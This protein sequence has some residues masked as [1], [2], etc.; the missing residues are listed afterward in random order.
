MAHKKAGSNTGVAAEALERIANLRLMYGV[1]EGGKDVTVVRWA[2]KQN[3]L[4]FNIVPGGIT[5]VSASTFVP[6]PINPGI[7]RQSGMGRLRHETVYG[8]MVGVRG[9]ELRVL[10]DGSPRLGCLGVYGYWPGGRVDG[11]TRMVVD[12]RYDLSSCD[13]RSHA[14][15]MDCHNGLDAGFWAVKPEN[16]EDLRQSYPASIGILGEVRLWGAV[17]EHERGWRAE[18]MEIVSLTAISWKATKYLAALEDI[19]LPG[20]VIRR[21]AMQLACRHDWAERIDLKHNI[22]MAAFVPDDTNVPIVPT[23]IQTQTY[24]RKCGLITGEDHGPR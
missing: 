15:S 10:R 2:S 7:Y 3:L 6:S 1:D 19:Y 12:P 17:V 4:S 22:P 18:C 23:T 24:C 13:P 9:W 14:S 21:Q 20:A 5:S 16:V 8:E 11:T